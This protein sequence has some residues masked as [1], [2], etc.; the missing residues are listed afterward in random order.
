MAMNVK[1]GI[2]YLEQGEQVT[3]ARNEIN[4]PVLSDSK[5]RVRD[6]RT[7]VF[8]K[9]LN[10]LFD[11]ASK[12]FGLI[13]AEVKIQHNG[14]DQMPT[15]DTSFYR[16]D[17]PSPSVQDVMYIEDGVTYRTTTITSP[18]NIESKMLNESLPEN[19]RPDKACFHYEARYDNPVSPENVSYHLFFG[20]RL[21]SVFDSEEGVK[22]FLNNVES[23]VLRSQKY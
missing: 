5:S 15:V 17:E 6:R 22:L 3:M 21:L 12:H 14:A 19:R 10:D 2:T 11:I 18:T 16:I 7:S 20:E 9:S 23:C 13:A 1:P 8:D 4:N